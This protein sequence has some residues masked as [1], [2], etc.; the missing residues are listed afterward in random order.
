MFSLQVLTDALR[1]ECLV[2]LDGASVW[3]EFIV[4]LVVSTNRE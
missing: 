1:K 3:T 4:D 2:L